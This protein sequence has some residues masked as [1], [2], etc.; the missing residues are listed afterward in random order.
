[1]DGRGRRP[2]CQVSWPVGI[3]TL[4]GFFLGEGTPMADDDKKAREA[5][6]KRLEEEIDELTRKGGAVA[7]PRSPREFIHQKMAEEQA[8][9]RARRKKKK[10]AAGLP[11]ETGPSCRRSG[12][13]LNGRRRPLGRHGFE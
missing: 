6:A 3:I 13:G 4:G 9:D 7:P 10:E 8:R 5:E 2:V 12:T 1:R 11:A